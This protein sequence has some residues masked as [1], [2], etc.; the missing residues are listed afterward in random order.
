MISIREELQKGTLLFDGA[1]G[2]YFSSLPGRASFRCERANL[3]Y[4]EEVAAIHEAYMAAGCR[5]I[6][7]NTFTLCSDLAEGADISD[8][9][10]AACRIALNAAA[11]FE[12]HVFADLGPAPAGSD[13]G[14]VYCQMADRF[15]ENGLRNF[16]VETLSSA[17]GIDTLAAHLQEVCPDAFLLVSYA[18][19]PDGIT[20]SGYSGISLLRKTAAM[21]G[22]DGVGLNCMSGPTHMLNYVRTLP[23]S[24][25]SCFSVMPNAGYPTVLG[26]RTVF[27]GDPAHFAQ[28][29]IR[30]AAAGAAIIGGCCGTTPIHLEKTAHALADTPPETVTQ[31]AVEEK[32]EQKANENI[33]WN[34][35]EAGQ[36]VIA[37]ELDPPVDDTIDSFLS[38]VSDLKNAGADIIT[39]ADCPVGRPRADSSLLACKIHRELG[40]EALPHMTCRDRNLFATKA[41]LL[42]LSIEGI[43]NVL[44]VT[45]DPIP[46]ADRDEVKSVFNFNSRKLAAYVSTLNEG[47]LK[48]PF[49]MFGALNVNSKNFAIQLKLA[50]EKEECGIS[51]FLTQ[52]IL[53]P[54]AV[55]NLKEARKVLR[56]KILGGIYPIVSHRNACF[57]NNEIAGIHVSDEIVAM[58]E[59]KDREQ[60]EALAV[61][62]SAMIAKEI[63]PYTDGFYLMTPFQR[64][65]LM[66]RIIAKIRD[67]M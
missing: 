2:T 62:L 43:H 40:V 23:L 32:A 63:N 59:G 46:T 11:P 31:S 29:M 12:A 39:I 34:K 1:M 22:V 60:S 18:V 5:A 19:G 16:L 61:E 30:I 54:E 24:E 10:D 35:L 38:G 42:G 47:T 13:A 52:P 53:S 41:L 6:K 55:E 15:L 7:T 14:A 26:C 67:D 4:P 33:L 27:N 9:L 36:R 57:M 58:Y 64:T 51:G 44:L 20:R 21:P 66:A 45:G 48:T 65:S 25:F 17:E 56:G 49:R 37:V 3:D 8:M 50:Q 28:Q